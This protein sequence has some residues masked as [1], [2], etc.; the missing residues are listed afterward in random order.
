[1]KAQACHKVSFEKTSDI[2]IQAQPET[3]L[4]IK[5]MHQELLNGLRD[6]SS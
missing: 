3:L 5:L 4:P 6:L 2:F 1:M